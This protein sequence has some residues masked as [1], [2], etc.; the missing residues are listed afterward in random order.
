MKE[1][2]VN[3][4][5]SRRRGFPL[6]EEGED[7][8]GGQGAGGLKLT[9]FLA[10]E[11]LAG[12]IE[13][14]NGGN[15]ALEGH[16]VLL[17]EIE[18]FVATADV[19]MDDYKIFVEEGGD[20]GAVKGFVESVAIEAPIGAENDK[21]TFVR[22]RGGMERFVDL[23]FGVGVFRIEDFFRGSLRPGRGAQR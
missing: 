10:E 12:G 15:A 6:V 2:A 17:G 16:L 23:P 5:R 14:G 1:A 18:V 21:N 20:F 11:E 19:H 22:G 13:N 8:G 4:W 3:A 9:L 7:V